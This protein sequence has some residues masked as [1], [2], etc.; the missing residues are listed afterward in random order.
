MPIRLRDS[1][2]R[3]EPGVGR[4]HQRSGTNQPSVAG[5]LGC[6]CRPGRALLPHCPPSATPLGGPS[7][8]VTTPPPEADRPMI[9]IPPEDSAIR[10]AISR[11]RPVDP[12]LDRPRSVG[13]ACG[14]P[15]PLVRDDQPRSTWLAVAE[16]DSTART[17]RRVREHVLKQDVRT[18]RQV[19]TGHAHRHPPRWPRQR[20]SGARCPRQAA[21]RTLPAP[22]PLSP[23]HTHVTACTGRATGFMDD[24]ADRALHG[25]D[26][27]K[28]L[29]LAR[30]C[31]AAT[32]RRYARR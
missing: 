6:N 7:P 29:G 26:I 15:G 13:S 10:R 19:L 27:I 3:E 21:A 12:I 32:R 30:R 23:P 20:S 18:G 9:S 31:R 24:L 14:K 22:R 4:C 1:G 5:S 11:P 25:A 17:V 2:V 16:P 28:Q 8:T